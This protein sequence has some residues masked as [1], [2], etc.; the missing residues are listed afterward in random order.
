MEPVSTTAVVVAAAA[1][2]IPLIVI[3]IS[4]WSIASDVKKLVQAYS[5]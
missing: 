2:A 3:G 5:N 4:L 1:V